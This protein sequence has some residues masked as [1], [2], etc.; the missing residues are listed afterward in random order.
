MSGTL[1]SQI[2]QGFQHHGGQVDHVEET[3]SG[4]E[5]VEK[6]GELFTS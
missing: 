1:K 4:Q 6:A 5:V 2:S 3:E